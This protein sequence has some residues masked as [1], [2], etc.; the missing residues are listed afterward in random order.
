MRH[1]QPP[2]HRITRITTSFNAY[3]LSD[4]DRNLLKAWCFGKAP[5]FAALPIKVNLHTS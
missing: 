3:T 1:V 4:T 5:S 2:M